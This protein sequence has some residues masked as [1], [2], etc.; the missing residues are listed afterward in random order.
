MP[1]EKD[2]IFARL[3][4]ERGYLTQAQLEEALAAQKAGT[5]ATGVPIPLS[6][7]LVGRNLL[8]A[9]QAQDLANAVAVQTGEAR[10]VAGYEVVAKIGQG[11]MG[12]VYK[13]KKLDTGESVAGPREY[14][15]LRRV[16]TRPEAQALLLRARAR[17]GRGPGRP[18]ETARRPPRGRGGLG[19]LPGR[20]GSPARALQRVG[21]P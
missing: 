6:Q 15:I 1:L 9:D 20:E 21:P 16:R 3:A 8:T 7:I 4:A 13:A 18:R 19:H 14:R 17:R 2:T 5:E 12:A 11:G 10:L